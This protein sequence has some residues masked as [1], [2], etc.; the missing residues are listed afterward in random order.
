MSGVCTVLKTLGKYFLLLHHLNLHAQDLGCKARICLWKS[1]EDLT[2]L[3][4]LM[5]KVLS[6]IQCV[7]SHCMIPFCPFLL[8]KSVKM[9]LL[10]YSLLV[11]T[12]FGD[13]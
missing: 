1:F 7:F 13:K 3:L 6:L 9:L 5:L 12:A 10:V 11:G 2:K 8:P 4:L